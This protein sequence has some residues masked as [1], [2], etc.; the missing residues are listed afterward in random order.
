MEI[1]LL[2]L[3]KHLSSVFDFC[4]YILEGRRLRQPHYCPDELYQLMLS[5][6]HPSA[7]NRPTF[8]DLVREIASVHNEIHG[9]H[10]PSKMF[11][12][13]AIFLATNRDIRFCSSFLLNKTAFTM[14]HQSKI[15]RLRLS[16]T[17]CNV[18]RL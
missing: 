10:Y 1:V 15:K 16:F 5:C 12:G 4:S 8:K 7:D 18:L 13:L 2:L 9:V 14:R 3:L 17:V 11:Q 6:W